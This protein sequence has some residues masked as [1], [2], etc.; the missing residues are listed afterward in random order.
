MSIASRTISR[1]ATHPWIFG[2]FAIYAPNSYLARH[3][4]ESVRSANVQSPYGSITL[5]TGEVIDWIN[6]RYGVMR[7]DHP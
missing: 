7:G 5:E 3:V 6:I 1:S 2:S 4:Y